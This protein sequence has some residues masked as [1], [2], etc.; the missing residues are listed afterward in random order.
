MFDTRQ[1]D[2]M[3]Y[4][5]TTKEDIATLMS[6]RLEMLRKVNG[7]RRIMLFQR[8][9]SQAANDIFR[10]ETRQLALLWRTAGQ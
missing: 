4:K 8:N 9:L 7:Y 6:I 10:R 1:G 2:A 3:E 5:I